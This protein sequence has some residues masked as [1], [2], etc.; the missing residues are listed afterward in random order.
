MAPLEIRYLKDLNTMSLLGILL[1]AYLSDYFF[2][3]GL[4]TGLACMQ[5]EGFSQG[6]I[7]SVTLFLIKISSIIDCVKTNVHPSLM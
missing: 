6:G 3:I 2:R 7:I 5:E 1:T 4:G